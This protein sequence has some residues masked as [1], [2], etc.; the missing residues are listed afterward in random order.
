M[1]FLVLAGHIPESVVNCQ[2]MSDSAFGGLTG[3]AR[4]PGL[5]GQCIP[6]HPA[7]QPGVVD[8]VSQCGAKRVNRNVQGLFSPRLRIGIRS[9]LPYSTSQRKSQYSPDSRG[10]ET[11]FTSQWEK[12]Q[13]TG[14][15]GET[16]SPK[17]KAVGE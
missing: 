12:L 3:S 16:V 8:R 5:R 4:V 10:G 9:L 2:S 15:G 7:G 6:C 13:N 1:V 11:E 17:M 14:K